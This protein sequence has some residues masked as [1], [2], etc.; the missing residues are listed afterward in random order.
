[1][2]SAF[3]SSPREGFNAVLVRPD[4]VIV[5]VGTVDF[6]Y[7]DSNGV[8]HPYHDVLVASYSS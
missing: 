7:T 8:Y 6:S 3:T 2:T 1:M 5:A 4:G